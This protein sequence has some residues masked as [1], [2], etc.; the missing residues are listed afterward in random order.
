M[1]D[2][3]TEP[4][5]SVPIVYDADV[6]VAGSGVAGSFA[7]LAAARSGATTILVDRFNIPG[8]HF[9]PRWRPNA[10]K[11]F[12]A[13]RQI[14]KGYAG[15]PLEFADRY[16]ALGFGQ[17]TASS[18]IPNNWMKNSCAAAYLLLKMFDEAGVDL[19]LCTW[20]SDAMLEGDTVVGLLVENKSGR[21]AVRAKVVIDATG[22]ADVARRAG[23]PI[24]LPQESY[25]EVDGH[26]PTGMGN[27]FTMLGVDWERYQEFLD[28]TDGR[29]ETKWTE[30]P[31]RCMLPRNLDGLICTGRSASCV[32]DTL[33]R[34]RH[35][36]GHMGQAAGTAAAMAAQ[37]GISPKALPVTEVQQELLA[38][39]FYLGEPDRL[40]EL[41]L[42]Q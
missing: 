21:G 19:L 12:S 27:W 6:V 37:Q 4:A 5:K 32:P 7:A 8:G 33:L 34:G 1:C 35:M 24:I 9:G 15:L 14:P 36:I 26:A 18:L 42:V 20:A 40:R 2:A 17:V 16:E 29:P 23:A 13:G 3:W 28:G 22:E 30:F 11:R 41:G 10:S 38:E 31:Y 39:G 25:R